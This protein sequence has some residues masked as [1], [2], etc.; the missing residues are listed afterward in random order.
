MKRDLLK[1]MGNQWRDNFWLTLELLIVAAVIGIVS[2]TIV[3]ELEVYTRP[4]GT[5]STEGIFVIN[6]DEI[7]KQAPDY[8][9]YGEDQQKVVELVAR[10]KG[11]MLAAI[12]ESKNVET[13]GLSQNGVPYQLNNSG[14]RFEL[15]EPSGIARVDTTPYY[16]N[17]RYITPNLVKVL[18][19]EPIGGYTQADIEK[20]LSNEQIVVSDF[21]KLPEEM[22]KH[23]AGKKMVAAGYDED[24]NRTSYA[25]PIGGLVRNMRRMAYEE[26]L[27]ATMLVGLKDG[28]PNTVAFVREWVV[29]VKPGQEEAFLREFSENAEMRRA[30]N[31]VTRQPVSLDSMKKAVHTESANNQNLLITAMVFLL[32]IVFL[33]LLGSFWYRISQREGEIAIRQVTGATKGDI[34]RRIFAEGMIL[35]LIAWIPA[36]VIDYVMMEKV[37]EWSDYSRISRLGGVAIASAFT[38]LSM[39][40]IIL[41]GLWF[42]ARKAMRVEPVEALKDE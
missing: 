5:G 2:M 30:G 24:P 15:L 13:V 16:T 27:Q 14:G 38:L 19:I 28:D 42:P 6:V 18:G 22:V 35:L 21:R 41:L 3:R 10:D 37:F 11:R 8:V 39:T 23:F 29:K 36:T 12:R 7:A 4:M 34:L 20:A 40:V 33:G 26:P 31:F 9:D 25:F 32:L 1:Q 17:M